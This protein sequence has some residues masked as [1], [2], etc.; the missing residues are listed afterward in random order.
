MAGDRP[1]DN[2]QIV[3]PRRFLEMR[4]D[5]IGRCFKAGGRHAESALA[6]R[7]I[8]IRLTFEFRSIELRDPL[9]GCKAEVGTP[10]PELGVM[11]KSVL[12][13]G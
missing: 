12:G 13:E 3:E 11:K 10:W 5:E 2:L 1:R 9:K 8:E 4:L 6:A 7:G